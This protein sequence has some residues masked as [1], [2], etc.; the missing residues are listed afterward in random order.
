MPHLDLLYTYALRMTCNREM[1]SSLLNDALLDAQRLWKL[2]GLRGSLE[3]EMLRMVRRTL[4]AQN[5]GGSTAKRTPHPLQDDDGDRVDWALLSLPELDRSAVVLRDINELSYEVI[6]EV[7]DCSVREVAASLHAGRRAL[8]RKIIP[9]LAHA[10]LLDED[11][12]EPAFLSKV[13]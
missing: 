4:R 12:R 3:L 5:R 9:S 7:L 10:A 11:E 6:A 2:G 8:A 13:G 1:A